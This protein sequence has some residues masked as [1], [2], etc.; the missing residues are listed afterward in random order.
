MDNKTADLAAR[1]SRGEEEAF[2]I[3]YDRE[4]SAMYRAALT[5]TGSPDLAEDA[6]QDVFLA[7][8]RAGERM[9]KVANLRGY[10]FT[11]VRRAAAKRINA[12]VRLT[13]SGVD[14][15][16]LASSASDSDDE[17]ARA[18]ARLPH[19]QREVVA[20]KIDGGLTFAEVREALEESSIAIQHRFY[21]RLLQ[22]ELRHEDGVGVVGAAPGQ[23]ASVLPVPGEERYLRVCVEGPA[24]PASE[25]PASF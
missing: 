22:H 6:V 24:F 3:L 5:I 10:L 12:A 16:Q 9:A 8:A 15:D 14:P 21:S 19:E 23:V 11:S 17:M 7:V 4:G 25:I 18:V 13:G 2:A 1:L 20:L